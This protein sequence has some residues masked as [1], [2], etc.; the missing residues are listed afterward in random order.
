[1]HSGLLSGAFSADRVAGLPDTDW[2][3]SSPDFTTGLERDLSVARALEPVAK[4][5][6]VSVLDRVLAEPMSVRRLVAAE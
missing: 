4:R 5:H 6:V 2:R 1:M 3:R